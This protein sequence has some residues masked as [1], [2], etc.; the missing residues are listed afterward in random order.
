M[1]LRHMLRKEISHRASEDPFKHL[2]TMYDSLAAGYHAARFSDA[3]GRY[4]LEETQV[5][6]KELTPGLFPS[7]G[8]L[9][10]DLACGTGKIAVTVAQQGGGRGVILDA[11]PTMLQRC[12]ARAKRAGVREK[13]LP[14]NASAANLPYRDGSFDVVFS[15]R[16]LHLFPV[17]IYSQL[18]QEMARVTKAGGHIVIEVKN[19]GYGGVVYWCKD[20]VRAMKGHTEFSS[21][22]GIRRLQALA[23]D[24]GGVTLQSVHGLLLPKG[25][26]WMGRPRLSQVTR[27]LARQPLRSLSAYLVAVYRKD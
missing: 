25:W 4:D 11:A 16:F 26:W 23:Q 3:H 2:A 5:L 18:V 1:K 10:L 13:L 6:I 14:T 21:S 24:V 9:A 15:F 22:M 12:L 7:Q 27:G 17:K 8:G 20:F 19:R